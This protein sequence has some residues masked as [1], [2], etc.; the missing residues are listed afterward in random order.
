MQWSIARLV[1]RSSTGVPLC[2]AETSSPVG[3]NFIAKMSA[4]PW[5][6]TPSA[7]LPSV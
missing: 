4:P 1:G 2:Q 5:L 6:V 7:T 3:A